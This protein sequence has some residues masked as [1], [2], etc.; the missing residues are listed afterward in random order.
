MRYKILTEDNLE[1]QSFKGGYI[2][3]SESTHVKMPHCWK[4]HVTAHIITKK[5]HLVVC[6]LKIPML[7]H[8]TCSSQT[9]VYSQKLSSQQLLRIHVYTNVVSITRVNTNIYQ[10]AI[11]PV[12][13]IFKIILGLF[14][15]S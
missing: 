4:S 3:L 13:G 7:Y 12:T 10:R 15:N 6:T 11:T 2:G 8:L 5:N 14:T 9:I 1:F